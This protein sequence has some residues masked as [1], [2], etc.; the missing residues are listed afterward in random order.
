MALHLR[1]DLRRWRGQHG[2]EPL[3][4]VDLRGDG[5]L[6]AAVDRDMVANVGAEARD[7][8]GPLRL[9]LQLA[10]DVDDSAGEDDLR[11]GTPFEGCAYCLS[12]QTPARCGG[13]GA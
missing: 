10:L 6:V 7:G 1:R 9:A 3:E 13:P 12:V 8:W 11:H 4:I 2:F 5:D